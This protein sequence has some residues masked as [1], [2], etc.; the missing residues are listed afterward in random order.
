MVKEFLQ[1]WIPGMVFMA[2]TYFMV[3]AVVV[4]IADWDLWVSIRS[5][6]W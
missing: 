1:V 2:A 6:L 5:Q 4:I 3:C